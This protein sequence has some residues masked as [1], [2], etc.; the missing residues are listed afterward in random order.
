MARANRIK[1]VITIKVAVG[2]GMCLIYDKTHTLSDADRA[3]GEIRY[4]GMQWYHHAAIPWGSKE[5]TISCHL[6]SPPATKV[7]TPAMTLAQSS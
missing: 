1:F 3:L 7:S 6:E 2:E 5:R 4:Q